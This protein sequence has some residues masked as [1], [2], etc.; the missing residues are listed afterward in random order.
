MPIISCPQAAAIFKGRWRDLASA[1]AGGTLDPEWVHQIR[2][3]LRGL[4][5]LLAGFVAAFVGLAIGGGL[6]LVLGLVPLLAYDSKGYRLGY[7]G[8]YYDATMAAMRRFETPPLF[9]G[10]GY[11]MQELERVPTHEGDQRLDGIL[12]ELGV[13]MFS[14]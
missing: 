8:G 13:S 11:S 10:V 9:I 5:S 2:I 14:A 1:D 12:T 3:T 4:R 6:G 7:G